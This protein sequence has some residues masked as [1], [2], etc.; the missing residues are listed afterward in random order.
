MGGT[1]AP[2]NPP[3]GIAGTGVTALSQEAPPPPPETFGAYAKKGEESNGV[4]AMM[5]LLIADLTKEKPAQEEYEA[6]MRDSTK[7]RMEDT[8]AIEDKTAAK[9]GM[10]EDLVNAQADLKDKTGEFMATEKYLSNLHLECDW[11]LKNFDLRKEARA[12]EIDALTQAKAVLSGADYSL[13]QTSSR[14][15]LRSGRAR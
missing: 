13:A 4:I 14:A 15:A 11:L 5:D 7:K 8:Q 9:A 6:M 10:E 1:L 3:G 12:G 2:T